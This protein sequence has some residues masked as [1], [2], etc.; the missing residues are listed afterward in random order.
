M[1]GCENRKLIREVKYIYLP[2]LKSFSL[3][4]TGFIF[5]T[6]SGHYRKLNTQHIPAAFL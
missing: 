2:D 1:Q 6:L 5:R 3:I 4:L